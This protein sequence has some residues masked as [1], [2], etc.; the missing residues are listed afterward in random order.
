M[1]TRQKRQRIK[2]KTH[3]DINNYNKFLLELDCKNKNKSNILAK[4]KEDDNIDD[5]IKNI[6]A[7]YKDNYSHKNFHGQC[8]FENIISKFTNDP[9]VY[10]SQEQLRLI[11]KKDSETIN[12]ICIKEK[13]NI[14]V[15]INNINDLL[16]LINDYPDKKEIE[17]NINIQLL[18]KIKE[19]LIELNN[20]IGH[21]D[22]NDIV[23]VL[24]VF[25]PYGILKVL[26]SNG[27]AGYCTT[28]GCGNWKLV[29]D[30]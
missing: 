16:T 26:T 28:I 1:N 17:Y 9:N 30:A 14:N 24:G 15:E 20:M 10:E 22:A 27:I 29:E 3:T 23:L 12:P 6:N 21:I 13:I 4:N 19:P 18:H 2:Y 5:I 7:N 8:A 11:N 25:P